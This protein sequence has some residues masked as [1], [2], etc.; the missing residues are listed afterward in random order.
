MQESSTM[1]GSG[2]P[3]HV[4]PYLRSLGLSGLGGSGG[5]GGLKTEKLTSR[6]RPRQ[7]HHHMVGEGWATVETPVRGAPNVAGDALPASSFKGLHHLVNGVRWQVGQ[8]PHLLFS[9][10]GGRAFCASWVW[11]IHLE[12]WPKTRWPHSWTDTSCK[13]ARDGCDKDSYSGAAFLKLPGA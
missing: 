12:A 11:R 9:H 6:R 4:T 13:R 3:R 8:A 2:Q 1:R 5:G 10:N 7:T